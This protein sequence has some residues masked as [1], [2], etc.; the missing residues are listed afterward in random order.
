MSQNF[1]KQL[2]RKLWLQ[3]MNYLKIYS[4]CIFKSILN[5]SEQA[6]IIVCSIVCNNVWN[7][8]IFSLLRNPRYMFVYKGV[9]GG[10]GCLLALFNYIYW[11]LTLKRN[12]TL[13]HFGK[14]CFFWNKYAV[15]SIIS[16][17]DLTSKYLTKDVSKIHLG[18]LRTIF[19][20][21]PNTFY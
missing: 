10:V 2:L 5:F 20:T 8:L 3:V 14:R 21:V 13:N 4:A 7:N 12:N 16:N 1:S 19:F 18:L 11:K 6:Q 17:K 9:G 15:L